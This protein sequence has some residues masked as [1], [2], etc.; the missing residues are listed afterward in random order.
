MLCQQEQ[1]QTSQLHPRQFFP[2]KKKSS[3][4][5]DLNP[6]HSAVYV[7]AQPTE[8]P[9]QPEEVGH[10]AIFTLPKIA[11]WN[12]I[13]RIYLQCAAFSLR[14]GRIFQTQLC[15]SSEK[16]KSTA[17]AISSL[18]CLPAYRGYNIYQFAPA[19][20]FSAKSLRRHCHR[21]ISSRRPSWTFAGL[22][23]A[24][25]TTVP[26]SYIL[27]YWFSQHWRKG[28]FGARYLR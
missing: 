21:F 26:S 6:R 15:N 27:V 13:R 5:Q 25:C 14:E 8:L 18:L 7:S 22:N 19:L 3:P 20:L 24:A 16:G 17:C 12:V 28:S 2:R 10:G 1:R 11:A 23:T 9:G 4:G